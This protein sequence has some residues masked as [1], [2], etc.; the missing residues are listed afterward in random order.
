MSSVNLWKKSI[1]YAAQTDIGLRRTNNQD[2]H[3]V[4]VCS[5]A[6]Q[7]LKHGHLFVVAD[8]MGAHLAGEVASRLAAET[9][10]KSYTNHHGG[11]V[12]QLAK[13][14]LDAHYAVRQKSNQEAY[15]AMGTTCDA[16][17]LTPKGLIIAHVGDSRVYRLRG[18]VFEQL[19]FDHSVLWEVCAATNT[20]VD[21]PPN[22]I[23]KNQI[24]R[25]VGPIENLAV[26]SEGPLPIQV[27]DI[28]LACSDGLTGQIKDEEIGQ[29]LTVFP[30][31]IAVE[32]LVNLANLRGGPDNITLIVVQATAD[33]KDNAEVE[34]ALALPA[35]H[36]GILLLS[37][38]LLAGAV[39]S[40]LS[41]FPFPGLV[42]SIL[43]VI[44][45]GCFFSVT[46]R[47][48]FWGSPFASNT[49]PQGKCPYRHWDCTPSKE[50]SDALLKISTELIR[51]ARE[52][53]E[54]PTHDVNR[55]REIAEA[56]GKAGNYAEVIRHYALAI[57]F[58]MRELKKIP[59]RR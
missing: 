41:G 29:I 5:N 7:W 46:K 47:Q 33:E 30:P 12:Q 8:G 4:K 38:L 37:L 57:N 20:L 34:K 44:S 16:F 1:R 11:T 25:S 3:I 59:K 15:K 43:T 40:L 9:V 35:W 26:D 24:T 14:V 13:A 49:P 22:Y 42:M 48:P 54:I 10:T 19:T 17:A 6:R 32:T 53:F 56:A 23:P 39:G 36:W 18:N 28:F 51:A 58:L 27:G 2:S 52:K 55:E 31:D 50:V 21:K 45:G